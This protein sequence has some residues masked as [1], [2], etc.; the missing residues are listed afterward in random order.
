MRWDFRIFLLSALLVMFLSPGAGAEEVQKKIKTRTELSYV[1]T[2]GNTDTQTFSV[3]ME[4]K[5]EGVK[6]RYF[7]TAKALYAKEDGRETS[8]KLSLDGSWERVLTERLFSLVTSGFSMDKFSGYEYRLYGGPGLGYDLVKR[9]RHVLQSLLSVV[10]NYD[11]YSVGEVSS[12]SYLTGKVTMKY[13]W[14][15][16]ENLKFREKLDY[17]VSFKDRDNFFLDS[18][19][20]IEAR[21]NRALSL[22]LSYVVSYQNQLPSPE[23]RHTDTTFLTTLIIDF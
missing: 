7:L 23:L 22:G 19:T 17:S 14:K 21:I 1:E 12:D 2:S 13:E 11:E 9:V 5:K 8:N 16:L 10:Y 6:N 20:S 3:S 18:S 15:M 4:T